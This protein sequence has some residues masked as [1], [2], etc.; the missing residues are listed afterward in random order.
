MHLFLINHGPNLISLWIG[1]YDGLNGPGSEN[2]MISP[3]TWS[4]IGRETFL[5]S[6]TIPAAFTRAL[7]NIATDWRLYNAESW[8]FWL[9]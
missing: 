8:S 9:Q 4:E 2:H 3:A 5:S 1:K 6:R 7:P